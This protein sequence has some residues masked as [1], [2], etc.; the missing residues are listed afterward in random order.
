MP[1]TPL[2]MYIHV[3]FCSRRCGYCAFNTYVLSEQSGASDIE[4]DP[5]EQYLEG[6]LAEIALADESLGQDRPA[7]HSIF[8]GGGTP[9][10]LSAEQLGRILSAIVDRF[11]VERDIE[12]TVEAN[13]DELAP[14]QL[15][16]LRHRGATRVSFGMQSIQPRILK[17]LDRT[18]DPERSL[19]AVSEARLAGFDHISLDLIYGTPGET[20]Q[21]FSLTLEAA[22]STQIDHL[23]AYALSIEPS[24]KLAARVRSGALPTPS[25]DEAADRYLAAEAALQRAGFN[26]YEISNWAANPSA[27]C[28]HNLLYWRNHNWWGIGP[29]AHSHLDG[30]RWWNLDD[31]KLWAQTLSR[32]ASPISGSERLTAEQRHLEDLMLGI[33]LAEGLPP[34]LA[35]R[36]H[37]TERL[38]NDGLATYQADRLVLTL[39]GRLLADQVISVLASD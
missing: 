27:Q 29:G 34:H 8:F 1:S 10:L 6:V 38:L 30:R 26:W 7:L 23:S 3:P 4:S 18:H 24:T 32:G 21:D 17:L 15:E 31:P 37:R 11:E 12:V 25:S 39:N 14:G 22:L 16:Q 33:R 35:P 13:P 5:I 19:Q 9:T 36:D 20:E 28:Q 2:G